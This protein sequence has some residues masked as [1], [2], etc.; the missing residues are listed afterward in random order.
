MN[1][2]QARKTFTTLMTVCGALQQAV[3]DKLKEETMEG[4]GPLQLK[5][6]A[7]CMEQDGSTQQQLANQVGRDKGQVAHLL[8]ALES[9]GLLIRTPDV[10]DKRVLRLSA[11]LEG[12][13]LAQQFNA[14]ETRLA[15]AL[16]SEFGEQDLQAMAAFADKMLRRL[17][18]GASE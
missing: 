10:A 13:R 11:T 17:T 5:L 4:L 9:M 15:L 3:K 6:L 7:L 2:V 16:F 12:S 1:P 14:L 18:A 8:H